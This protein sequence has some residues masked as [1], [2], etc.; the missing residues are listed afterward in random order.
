MHRRR[1]FVNLVNFPI[2]SFLI[3]TKFSACNAKSLSCSTFRRRECC[4]HAFLP[5]SQHAWTKTRAGETSFR[6]VSTKTS[7]TLPKPSI[8]NSIATNTTSV[9]EKGKGYQ[10]EKTNN[11]MLS[12]LYGPLIKTIRKGAGSVV[13][14]FGF[15]SS[16]VVSLASN[17]VPMAGRLKPIKALQKFL[18][19]TG[20]DLELAPSLNHRLFTN[21]LLLQ[22]VQWAILQETLGSGDRRELAEDTKSQIE[23]PSWDEARR[24]MRYST[25]VYGQAM[26]RAAELDARGR[27]D[28]RLQT[29]T[30]ECISEHIG[31]PT[32]DIVLMDVDYGGDSQHLRHFV[33]VDH[34]NKKVVLSIRG[35]FSLSEVVVDVAAF[36]RKYKMDVYYSYAP[37]SSSSISHFSFL[38]PC[39]RTIGEFCGGE[40]HSEMAT[41]AERVWD[42]AGPTVCQLLDD[43]KGY[44]V[45]LTGHSLGA[46][47]A[48]LLNI[49]C[50]RN[51][52]Q[53]VNGRKVQC[54]AY[55]SPPVFTPLEFVPR[56]V[57]SAT[58]YIHEE[59][60]VPFLSVHSVRHCFASIRT[61]E[62]YPTEKLTRKDRAAILLGMKEPP[63]ELIEAVLRA[64]NAPLEPKQGSPRL[65]IPSATSV[66][67]REDQKSGLISFRTCEPRRLARLGILFHKNMLPDH[68]PPRYEHALDHIEESE[69]KVYTQ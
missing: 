47:T 67:L 7:E 18:E 55:A 33:A 30:K 52:N 21:I 29:V 27:I 57:E 12:I 42:A 35:T 13:S 11:Q 26:I 2:M 40:G 5:I 65:M 10:A 69:G 23:I 22:K 39:F 43:N 14:G 38:N 15:F 37:F 53:L 64:S 8:Q 28:G 20:I 61:I 59:D 3:L 60:T 9:T 4:E 68:F 51:N 16:S 45:I 50:H 46:G 34:V 19:T 62:E 48:S 63:R 41:M 49:M 1:I 32:D 56:A 54:F 66:W 31:V 6:S 25:A 17:K 24:Y 36:S 58:N 44:S